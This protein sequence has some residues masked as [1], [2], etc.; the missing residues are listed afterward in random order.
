MSK[1]RLA[2]VVLASTICACTGEAADAACHYP[3]EARALVTDW[4]G[5]LAAGYR[6]KLRDS[7][8]DATTLFLVGVSLL[9][10]DLAEAV[11]DF[12]RSLAHDAHDPW[13]YFEL[14]DVY[15]N[16]QP[17]PSKLAANMR[18][19]RSLCPGNGDAFRYLS[20][21]S[22]RAE[23]RAFAQQLRTLLEHTSATPDLVR[24][25]DLWAA[26]FRS[27]PPSDFDLVRDRIRGDLKRLAPLAQADRKLLYTL[28]TGYQ[29][30]GETEAA[31]R[32]TLAAQRP[33]D[34]A[35]AALS[36]WDEQHPYSAVGRSPEA[37]RAYR[38]ARRKE[39]EELAA[40]W[41]DSR[42][43]WSAMLSTVSTSE[44]ASQAGERTIQLEADDPEPERRA[45]SYGNVAQA[46]L[47]YGVR[48]KDVPGLAAQAL[49]DLDRTEA[50]ALPSGARCWMRP[51][52]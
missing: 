46:W 1:L 34:P 12:D 27:A 23:T 45:R 4:T 37:L 3:E 41:P 30:I 35:Q 18:A 49:R 29:L 10:T 51:C 36:A 15:A 20:R 44:Q 21:I 47:K 17:D 32:A 5:S 42:I 11:R 14:M 38:E 13:P 2:V 8:E 52:L 43:S 50:D 48:L 25:A 6:A 24:Y 39:A 31:Q 33:S 7:P 19:Y 16:L 22:D 40:K 28:E 26:E 9:S